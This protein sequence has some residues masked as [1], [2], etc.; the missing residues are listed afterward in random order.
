MNEHDVDWL[1]QAMM[2][3]DPRITRAML[4]KAEPSAAE[5]I[6]MAAAERRVM[7]LL[8]FDEDDGI[9]GYEDR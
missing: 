1:Q 8:P 3:I 5:G 2:K 6:I 4:E 7:G 9:T